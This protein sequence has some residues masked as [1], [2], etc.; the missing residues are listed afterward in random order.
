MKILYLKSIHT[1]LDNDL[2]GDI[3]YRS[4]AESFSE[5]AIYDHRKDYRNTKDYS[6][7]RQQKNTPSKT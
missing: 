7:F 5:S 6:E 2:A 3:T 4:I 1:Y